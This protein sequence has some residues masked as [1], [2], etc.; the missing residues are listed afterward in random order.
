M[1]KI[2]DAGRDLFTDVAAVFSPN[3]KHRYWWQ[4]EWDA[5]LP[6][7]VMCALNP[8]TADEWSGD[9]TVN[10]MVQRAR[11]GGQGSFIIVNLFGFRSTSPKGLAG[12]TDL[13]RIGADNDAHIEKAAREAVE[14]GG[15]FTCG[16]GVNA[17]KYH[18]G[19]GAA[20]LDIIRG[21]GATPMA[22]KVTKAGHP[23]HPLYLGYATKAEPYPPLSPETN[24]EA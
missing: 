20:V 12:L 14:R 8:S 4:A 16:W 21:A 5:S 6:P 11:N 15:V 3:R 18:Q 7:L 23:Q 17:E 13:E 19:R 22:Y 9:P 2:P 10:R 1:T 24:D